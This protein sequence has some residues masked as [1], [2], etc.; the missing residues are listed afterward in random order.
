MPTVSIKQSTFCGGLLLESG[1][2]YEVSAEDAIRLVAL[3]KAN[4][5]DATPVARVKKKTFSKKK[6]EPK[7]DSK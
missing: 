1:S 5:V 7:E 4:M 6:K 2:E 3:G